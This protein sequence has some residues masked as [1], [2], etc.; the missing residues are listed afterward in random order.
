ML[1]LAQLKV[2]QATKKHELARKMLGLQNESE[3]LEIQMKREEA[4]V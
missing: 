1:A 2:E 4:M 3:M